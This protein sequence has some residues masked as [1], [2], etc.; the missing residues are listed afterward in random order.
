[1]L[2]ELTAGPWG[3]T[4]RALRPAAP[5]HAFKPCALQMA[6]LDFCLELEPVGSPASPC[7]GAAAHPGASPSAASADTAC[8]AF[9]PAKQQQQQQQG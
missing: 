7:G 1:M 5:T 8:W 6:A 9:K 2:L 3:A 4:L